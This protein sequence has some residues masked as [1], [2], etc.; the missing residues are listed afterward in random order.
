MFRAT[1]LAAATALVVTTVAV[2]VSVAGASTVLSIT[3]C[4]QVVTTDAV[5][6][7]DLTC[8]GSALRVE[9]SG[10]IV[11]LGHHRITSSDGTDFGVVLG[12]SPL[13]DDYAPGDVCVDGVTVQG[14]TISGFTGGIGADGPCPGTGNEVT[15]TALS[16]NTWGLFAMNKAQVEL[17]HTS[18]VGPNGVGP[19]LK[20]GQTGVVDLFHSSVQVTSPGGVLVASLG[21]GPTVNAE[22]SQLLGPGALESWQSGTIACLAQPAEQPD[23]RLRGRQHP[24][25]RQRG[26]RWADARRH[27][28]CPVLRPLAVRRPGVGDGHHPRWSVSGSGRRRRVHRVGHRGGARGDRTF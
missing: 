24:R 22:S 23:D 16:D 11:R 18:I 20:G 25:D 10:V 14:G 7:T 4:G 5:L 12:R 3:S 27:R 9:A 17:S 2:P 26:P 19:N 6:R 13:P 28:M 15:G 8:A 1:R 21:F